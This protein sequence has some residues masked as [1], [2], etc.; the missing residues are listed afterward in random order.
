MDAQGLPRSG[1]EFFRA[2]TR[3]VLTLWWLK[4]PGTMIGIA[5]FFAAYFWVL[6]HPFFPVTVMP[7]TTMDAW[8]VFRPEALWLYVSLWFYV[9]LLPALLENFKELV[10]YVGQVLALSAAGLGIFIFWP[11]A[12]PVRAIDWAKHPGFDVLKGVDA[13][14]NACPSLHVAFAVFSAIGIGRVLREMRVGR[15]WRGVNWVWCAG[16][17]YSTVA[18]G[19]HVV[20]DV[21]AG[22]ALGAA[23]GFGLPW[24]ARRGARAGKTGVG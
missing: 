5:G 6:R 20:L 12:V 3:R 22:A 13:T 21:I 2:V 11:T 19:Q 8:I 4:M 17:G 24:M 14:G 10:A 16:I 15:A 1:A 18:I 7:L 9:G 23:A